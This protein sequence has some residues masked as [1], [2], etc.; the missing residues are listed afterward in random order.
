MAK[1]FNF[2]YV[3]ILFLSL[4]IFLKEVDAQ[5]TCK[6]DADCPKI[7]SLYPTIYKCLDGIC[8]FSE[9]KLLIL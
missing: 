5:R 9:A 7:P 8:R 6:T 1:I 2:V 4:H 3:M